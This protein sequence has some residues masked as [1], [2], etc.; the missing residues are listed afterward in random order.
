MCRRFSNRDSGK[1][2]NKKQQRNEFHVFSPR[3]LE[4]PSH[5]IWNSRVSHP[6]QN[7]YFIIIC[8]PPINGPS[9]SGP[10]RIDVLCEFQVRRFET[11]RLPFE[12]YWANQQRRAGD[13]SRIAAVRRRFH[14]YFQRMPN[15]P[16][17]DCHIEIDGRACPPTA[18]H[19]RGYRPTVI[20]LHNLGA[21]K[22]VGQMAIV[23]CGGG[24]G[25]PLQAGPVTVHGVG[26]ENTGA[27]D[28]E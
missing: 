28:A 2:K 20:T 15:F 7:V 27:H 8:A 3:K 11:T 23:E 16:R 12:Q 13:E 17:P 6:S 10:A 24:E 1:R 18:S 19:S 9:R 26:D 5:L 4:R 22:A 14:C 25:R 21:A